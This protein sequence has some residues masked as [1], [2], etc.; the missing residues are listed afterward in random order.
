MRRFVEVTVILHKSN[1]YGCYDVKY[2]RLID[3]NLI[4][5]IY[6]SKECVIE[7]EDEQ[8]FYV[9]KESYEAVRKELLVTE[10]L[11]SDSNN[12]ESQCKGKTTDRVV[13]KLCELQ[14]DHSCTIRA[15]HD[16]LLWLRNPKDRELSV[17]LDV[18]DEDLRT[19]FETCCNEAKRLN[20]RISELEEE[21]KIM[22]EPKKYQ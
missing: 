18:N 4:S 20:A 22:T 8:Y 21:V 10:E 1:T 11:Q 13:E 15:M 19:L 9:T 5:S 17:L 2:K 16:L 7:F 12:L 6:D 3:L 14:N